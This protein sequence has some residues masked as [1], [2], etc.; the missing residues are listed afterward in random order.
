VIHLTDSSSRFRNSSDAPAFDRHPSTGAIVEQAPNPLLSTHQM[1]RGRYK[2]AVLLLL[3][4]A[5]AGTWGGLRLSSV[6]YRSHASIR[7]LPVVTPVM[8]KGISDKSLMPMF[9]A[10]V[11][12]Q[13]NI[14]L[15]E[16]VRAKAMRNEEWLKL[17]RGTSEAETLEFAKA[18]RVSHEPGFLYVDV[19]DANPEAARGATK[20]IVKS[21]ESIYEEMESKVGG[22]RMQYLES[23]RA[24]QQS[25]Y[26][27]AIAKVAG[28]GSLAG[29][30]NLE[31]RYDLQGKTVEKYADEKDQLE[32]TLLLLQ[33][34]PSPNLNPMRTLHKC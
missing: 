1:L 32:R 21:Y 29:T 9:E 18:L 17:G 8:D 6:L 26:D 13:A 16:R 31:H 11:Q 3:I 22:V 7:V 28:L 27:S 24:R 19:L 25:D 15:G 34:H 14:L 20:A 33:T 10:Y 12:G 4:G 5:G 2:W 23:D 30:D